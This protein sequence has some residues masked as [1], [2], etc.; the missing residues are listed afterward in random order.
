LGARAFIP[1][2]QAENLLRDAGLTPG[3]AATYDRLRLS[4]GVP[5]SDRDL[6]P[7]KSI[8]LESGFDELHGVDWQKGCYMGQELTART[9][10]RGLVRKRLLPVTITGPAPVPGTVIMAG[11]KE[12]GELR[13]ISDDGSVGLAMLR[14]EALDGLRQGHPVT[15]QADQAALTPHLPNWL[16]LPP[17]DA[18]VR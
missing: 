8:L 6:V 4:L 1:A 12:V 3:D 15:L 14:L 10:Y 16:I 13:S 2:A 9:K 17:S 7:D 18:A 5:E 11:E